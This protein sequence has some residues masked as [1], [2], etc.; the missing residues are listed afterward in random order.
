[1]TNSIKHA[2]ASEIEVKL[3]FNNNTVSLL[4]EDNG[5]GFSIKEKTLSSSGRGMADFIG[6]AMVLSPNQ[7]FESKVMIGTRFG[8]YIDLKKIKHAII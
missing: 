8:I 2:K 5:I 1:M 6:R 4:M 3:N 7:Y